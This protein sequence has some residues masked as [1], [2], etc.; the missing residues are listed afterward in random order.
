MSIES[1]RVGVAAPADGAVP[2]EEALLTGTPDQFADP[3]GTHFDASI[4]GAQAGAGEW[5]QLAP[6]T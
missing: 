5:T 2:G 1:A 6:T 3:G 4:T